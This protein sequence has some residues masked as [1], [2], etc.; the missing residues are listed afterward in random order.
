M[1]PRFWGPIFLLTISEISDSVSDI[2]W[3]ID[4]TE[5]STAHPRC[6]RWQNIGESAFSENHG[7]QKRRRPI[8]GDQFVVYAYEVFASD[9]E[10]DGL[11]DWLTGRDEAHN[12]PRM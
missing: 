10:L 7:F 3:E 4:M 11:Y 9:D 5:H 12:N 2:R 1:G 6:R 8:V